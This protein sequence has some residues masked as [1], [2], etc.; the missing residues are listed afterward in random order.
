MDEQLRTG[1]VVGLDGSE[2]SR[3]AVQFAALDAERRGAGLTL[4]HVVPDLK[5]TAPPQYL[6][7]DDLRRDV[8]ATARALL[9]DATETATQTAPGVPLT[10]AM[11][12]GR[13]VS[14]L[15]HESL[16]AIELVV[17]RET[18]SPVHR[19]ATGAVTLGAAA[20]A[21]R[22]V[23]SVPASWVPGPRHKVVAGYKS[24]PHSGELLAT[25]FAEAAARDARLVLVHTWALD[26]LYDD[27]IVTRTRRDEWS[28]AARDGIER[29]L[30]GLRQEYPAVRV[31]VRALHGPASAHA[32]RG[33]R[34]RGPARAHAPGARLP[35]GRPP[36]QHRPG[37]A[38]H[39]LLPGA[40]ASLAP[41]EHGTEG[42]TGATADD[43]LAA[44]THR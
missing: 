36:G 27:R 26:G 30:A 11:P 12:A 40:G 10:Q 43:P 6:V 39:R 21:A 2:G 18:V 14:R 20:R 16:H 17:G 33:G 19:L 38:A 42:T 34:G 28:R 29:D 35:S 22:P 7:P 3:R 1:V 37:G 31:E 44:G 4:V 41:R 8:E 9:A 24:S 5:T 13:P 25:A 23:V 32:G 15:L